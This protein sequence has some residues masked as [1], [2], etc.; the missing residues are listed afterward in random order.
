MIRDPQ[1][2]TVFEAAHQEHA[3]V[4]ALEEPLPSSTPLGGGLYESQPLLFVAEALR[5]DAARQ[6]ELVRVLRPV[7]VDVGIEE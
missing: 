4:P 3:W 5:P 2:R 7:L 6:T 1:G